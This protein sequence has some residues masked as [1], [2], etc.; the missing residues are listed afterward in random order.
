METTPFRVVLRLLEYNPL[1]RTRYTFRIRIET[2]QNFAALPYSLR[3]DYQPSESV[4]RFTIRGLDISRFLMPTA[5]TEIYTQDFSILSDGSTHL[6]IERGQQLH[7]IQLRLEHGKW[8][9]GV[10][11]PPESIIVEIDDGNSTHGRS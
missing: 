9:I 6:I 3:V 1:R 8:A 10:I 7:T 11:E 2:T 5:P 4:H